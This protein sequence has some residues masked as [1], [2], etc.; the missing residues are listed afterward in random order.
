MHTIY[1]KRV[2]FARHCHPSYYE[3]GILGW[4]ED[5]S[6]QGDF[7]CPYSGRI[8]LETDMERPWRPALTKVSGTLSNI[9]K[10]NSYSCVPHCVRKDFGDK[11]E[12]G[13]N[14]G[15]ASHE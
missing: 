6:N 1:K 9:G 11:G 2:L 3:S 15:L 4:L 7:W 8:T 12:K 5:R 13:I 14:L 10:P